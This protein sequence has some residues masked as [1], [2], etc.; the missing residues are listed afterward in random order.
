ME[1]FCQHCSILLKT[2]KEERE[3][4]SEIYKQKGFSGDHLEKTVNVITRDKK[5]WIDTMM[6]DEF[7]IMEETKSPLKA[8][9]VTFLAFNIIG[10]IPLFSYLLSYVSPF[11]KENAFTS[12]IIFT[13]FAL[14]LVGSIKAN[15]VDK[16]WYRSGFE[17]F[18][19]GGVAAAIAYFVGYSLKGFAVGF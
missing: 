13:S 19:I 6:T 4:I 10:I 17:T 18:M 16:K 5:I 8:A 2:V 9:L 12:S 7:G 14:F 15:I 3:E 1:G 11:F